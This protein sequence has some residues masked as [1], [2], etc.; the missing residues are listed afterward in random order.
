MKGFICPS[1]RNALEL[2]PIGHDPSAQ[3]GLAFPMFDLSDHRPWLIGERPANMKPTTAVLLLCSAVAM[4]AVGRLVWI[5][6]TAVTARESAVSPDGRLVANIS[7]RWSDCFFGGP[8]YEMH[9]VRIETKGGT[10]VRHLRSEEPW[11]GWPKDSAITWASDSTS[12]AIKFKVT[13]ALPTQIVL[14]AIE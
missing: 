3:D 10:L 5:S 1:H 13:E 6:A 7:S 2:V 14:K 8:P 11:A 4:A 9:D 12:C